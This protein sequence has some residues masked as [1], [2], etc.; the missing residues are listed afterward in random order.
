MEKF[1]C[2]ASVSIPTTY[3]ITYIRQYVIV[4]I[5]VA[6]GLGQSGY[7]GQM[8]H[9]FSGSSSKIR[10]YNTLLYSSHK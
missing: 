3:N 2:H 6:T 7:P 10:V 1:K 4:G 5:S 9:F 8:G